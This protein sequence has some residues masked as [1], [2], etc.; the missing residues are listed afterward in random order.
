MKKNITS[1][2]KTLI[3]HN[4]MFLLSY[5]KLSLSINGKT[6]QYILERNCNQLKLQI[7]QEYFQPTTEN[8]NIQH[9]PE[10]QYSYQKER[11]CC[12]QVSFDLPGILYVAKVTKIPFLAKLL[13]NAA[14][15]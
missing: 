9:G 1:F 3:Q 7:L 11:V 12:S 8:R 4:H 15:H 14:L 10:K 2:V 13:Y 6:S 5:I